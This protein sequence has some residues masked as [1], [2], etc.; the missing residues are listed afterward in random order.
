MSYTIT[1]Y[2]GSDL[3]T[4]LNTSGQSRITIG[5]NS[6][7][8]VVIQNSVIS[9]SHAEITI[10]DNQLYIQDL[11]STNGT[12][13]DH[14]KIPQGQQILIGQNTISLSG[15]VT[16]QIKPNAQSSINSPAQSAIDNLGVKIQQL[17]EQKGS[18]I[19]GRSDGADIRIDNNLVS[20][21]HAK[22]STSGGHIYVE[23]LGSVNGTF[24]NGQ[25]IKL[26]TRISSSDDIIVGRLR[27]SLTGSV[28][29]ISKEI[30]IKTIGL[31]KRFSNGKVG[32]HECN[33]EIPSNSLLAVMGPSGCGKSTLLK[34]LNGES[35]GSSGQVFIGGQELN[36]Y[37]DYLKMQIGYVPQDDIVH[38]ELTVDQSLWY[39]GKLRLPQLTDQQLKTKIN[40]V[41]D[42]LNISHIRSN[43]VSNI[44]GG[45]RKRVSIAVE[46]L[47]DPLILFLDEP[48]SPLD[49]QTIED[50]LSIL[51]KLSQK[52]TTVVMVTHKPEDLA[53]MDQVIFMAEGGHICYY[54]KTN[55]YLQFF[56]VE[57]TVKVYSMLIDDKKDRW[58][59]KYHSKPSQINTNTRDAKIYKSSKV[60]YFSQYLWLTKR[61]LTIKMN[62]KANSFIMLVQSPIIAIII[63]M[64]FESL[65]QGVTFLMA[66]A[67][68]WLGANNAA[69]EIVSE[70]PIFKRERMFNQGILTYIFSKITVLMLFSAVQAFLFVGILTVSFNSSIIPIK[71]PI[72]ASFWMIFISLVATLMGLLLSATVSTSEKVMS[73]VPIALIPQIMLAGVLTKISSA[74]MEFI[75]YFSISRWATEGF[76]FI[77][78]DIA[79][80]KYVIKNKSEVFVTPPNS[81][82]DPIID[83]E[84]KDG[85]GVDSVAN[86]LT[87]IQKNYHGNYINRFGDLAG[88]IELDLYMLGS[89]S[90]L[91]FILIFVALRNKD[92]IQIK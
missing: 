82:A 41:L 85:K 22:I 74:L 34:A 67:S 83:Q 66:I 56:G 48:T 57:D 23:D 9:G 47:T 71:D 33:I 2:S 64:L 77:Q 17:L 43:L 84:I 30:A 79:I 12:F 62:D 49:P 5:R 61:Y 11:G 39:S 68:L 44:S 58:V 88:T 26:K 50:F 27:F 19:L 32:L 53:Y 8:T 78:H 24:I 15:V 31:V 20:R 13:V 87:Q 16:V 4:E 73:L 18:V 36:R 55:E 81:P 91:F 92:T 1:I 6:N 28:V 89:L 59:A 76:N 25:R 42:E 80:P 63:V 3:V 46:I 38:R 37:F 35:P 90:V 29:D 21:Q 60:D 75:S 51:R 45:Q 14:I 70:A 86:A 72:I 10:R 7:N 54:G 40:Q 52:G 65:T 69:R